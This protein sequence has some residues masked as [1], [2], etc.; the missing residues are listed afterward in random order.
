MRYLTKTERAKKINI[1]QNVENNWCRWRGIFGRKSFEPTRSQWKSKC[2]LFIPPPKC[3][4]FWLFFSLNTLLWLLSFTV[5]RLSSQRCA[6]FSS[7]LGHCMSLLLFLSF[8]SKQFDWF[9][10]SGKC[11]HIFLWSL[12]TQYMCQCFNQLTRTLVPAITVYFAHDHN[13]YVIYSWIGIVY[14][15]HRTNKQ[16]GTAAALIAVLLRPNSASERSNQV[17]LIKSAFLL[18]IMRNS[19]SISKHTHTN[20]HHCFVLFLFQ[21]CFN[22][23]V[24]FFA[25]A[26]SRLGRI[27]SEMEGVQFG[28]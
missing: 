1:S 4:C 3:V 16:I 25:V 26:I 14:L 24:F 27:F 9:W 8:P 7:S 6:S 19:K 20:G 10:L 18:C 5:C 15:K 2:N 21:F 11:T 28:W 23:I 12:Y 17:V 22:S 13:G